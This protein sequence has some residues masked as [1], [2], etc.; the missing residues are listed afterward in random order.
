MSFVFFVVILVEEGLFEEFS[1]MMFI[2]KNLLCFLVKCLTRRW[3]EVLSFSE[4]LNF[5]GIIV[6]LIIRW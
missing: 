5:L 4:I 1:E 2:L 3:S 6:V